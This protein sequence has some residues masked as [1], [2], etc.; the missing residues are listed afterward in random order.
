MTPDGAVQIV[1]QQEGDEIDV[2][3]TPGHDF[4]IVYMD[5]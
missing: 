3:G 2:T 1:A 4:F 5:S